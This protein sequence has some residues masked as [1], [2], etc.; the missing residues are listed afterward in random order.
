MLVEDD[1]EDEDDEDEDDE[2]FDESDALEGAFASEA[3]DPVPSPAAEPDDCCPVVPVA[4]VVPV[5]PV[6]PAVPDRSP[7]AV[8]VAPWDELPVR[9]RGTDGADA[10]EDASESG[11]VS[12]GDCAASVR[13]GV[14][15]WA[16]DRV[17]VGRV[18]SDVGSF[19]SA[20]V[21]TSGV[22]AACAWSPVCR[23]SAA[24][25]SPPPTRATAVATTARRWFFFQRASCRRRAARPGGAYGTEGEVGPLSVSSDGAVRGAV[26]AHG[27]GGG[28][29]D[30][31]GAWVGA[32]AVV[33]TDAVVDRATRAGAMPRSTVT[34]AMSGA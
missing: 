21:G 31:G 20:V 17:T 4:P 34:G 33:G 19:P 11:R 25:V 29:G 10:G 2:E 9:C 1:D 32:I 5:E 28:V 30:S 8:T 14:G 6:A 15:R 26:S 13:E 18:R 7:G 27:A 24:K 23:S 3:D 22:V 16:S 12:A